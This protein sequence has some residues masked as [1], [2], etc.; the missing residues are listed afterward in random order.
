M[1]LTLVHFART[2]GHAVAAVVL[3]I[4]SRG[5]IEFSTSGLEN[6]LSHLLII[7]F[8]GL[9]ATR[10]TQLRYLALSAALLALNR[11][12]AL[13]VVLPG[14]AHASYFGVREQGWKAALKELAIG[15]SPFLAWELFSLVYYGFPFPNTAYAKLN[16]G[17]PRPEVIRQG[18]VYWVNGLAWDAPIHIVAMFGMFT[19]LLQRRHRDMLIAL[20]LFGYTLYVIGIGGDFMQGRFWTIP[21]FT[22]AC[23][24]AISELPLEEPVRAGAVI[25]PFGFLFFHP[26]A[27]EVFPIAALNLSGIADERSFYRDE[28]SL[29]MFTRNRNMPAHHWMQMGRELKMKGEKTFAFDN[30]GFLG[31]GAGPSVHIVDQLALSEPLLARLPMRYRS[32]WRVGH[33]SRHVPDGFRE[34]PKVNFKCLMSDRDLCDYYAKL[35]V[36]T[37]GPLFGWERIKTVVGFNLGLY[38]HLI[39]RDRYRFPELQTEKLEAL[40]APIAERSYWNA[41]GARVISDDGI[42]IELPKLSHA[43]QVALSLDGNDGYDIEFRKNGK[44]V[45]KFDSKSEHVGTIRT[46]QITVPEGAVKDGFDHILVR[47]DGGDGMFSVG[48]VRLVGG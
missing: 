16:T 36:V 22:G 40:Q 48:Y 6:P 18:L 33:Y 10:N 32:S 35:R 7:V 4:L 12:D 17:L 20:G 29:V 9:Y 45:G 47:P 8:I 42:L 31:F 37:S 14:L 25:L 39:D 43:K 44:S 21:F 26:L 28:S 15:F 34:M 13:I 1:A 5:F 46:R 3:L 2:A 27:V 19:A 23:L 24:I 38:D 41:P 11:I 30:I